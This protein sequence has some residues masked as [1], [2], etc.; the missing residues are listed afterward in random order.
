MTTRVI[1]KQPKP[2]S[3]K[4]F[5][6][7]TKVRVCNPGIDGVVTQMDAERTV[8]SEYWHTIET[9][10][11]EKREPG[12]NLELIPEAITNATPWTPKVADSIHFHGPNPRLN[13]NSTDNSTNVVSSDRSQ[14]FAGLNERAASISDDADRERVLA[15]IAKMQQT[16]KSGG[17]LNAYQHFISVAADHLTLFTPFIPMLTQ[18]LSGHHF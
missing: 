18:M 11:G 1:Y 14:V 7:G 15:A 9:K 5:A 8:L 2:K 17:F 10:Y 13:I 6:V 3:P 4:R 12:C 16:E